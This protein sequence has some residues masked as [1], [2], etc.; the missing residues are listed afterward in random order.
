MF[1][2]EQPLV[3]PMDGKGSMYERFCAASIAFSLVL[4]FAIPVSA[5]PRMVSS[6]VGSGGVVRTQA[7]TSGAF[8]SAT[9][10]QPLISGRK[11]AAQN[12][13]WEGFWTPW[14]QQT[15][16]VLETVVEG[17]VRIYPNPMSES[18]Q[19]ALDTQ[20][21]G[22]VTVRVYDVAGNLVQT[23]E[24]TMTIAGSTTIAIGA[25]D[26]S[27]VRLAAGS[28]ACVVEGTLLSGLPYRA[29]ARLS[30]IR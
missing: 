27:G 9:I 1:S 19:I 14:K 29:S 5:Q 15:T 10:G 17:S 16:S 21:D 13:I 8:M 26:M 23:I 3:F 7:S 6:V 30:V 24:H 20:L 12:E 22:P 18:A 4:C 28:Y 11:A 2:N 25:T